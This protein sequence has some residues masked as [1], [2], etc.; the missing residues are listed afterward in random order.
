MKI[1]KSNLLITLFFCGA[2]STFA[3]ETS[4][5]PWP[6]STNINQPWARWWWMGS[7]V[8]K[9]NLKKSLTDFYKAGIGGGARSHIFRRPFVHESTRKDRLKVA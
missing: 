7:A 9:P 8:D 5:S 2:L 1:T 3:Q 6:K 4:G